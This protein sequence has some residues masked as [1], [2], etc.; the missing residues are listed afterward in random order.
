MMANPQDPELRNKNYRKC[1][2]DFPDM[3]H[4]NGTFLRAVFELVRLSKR[5]DPKLVTKQI[6]WEMLAQDI[7]NALSAGCSY[8]VL[9]KRCT[10]KIDLGEMSQDEFRRT[11]DSVRKG[12]L[13]RLHIG[14]E[15]P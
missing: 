6:E 12:K 7:C 14:E 10:L 11:A 15:V 5:D 13:D 8:D 3:Y 9:E 1:C 4:G 2:A